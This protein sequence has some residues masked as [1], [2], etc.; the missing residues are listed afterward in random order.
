MLI[1][2]WSGNQNAVVIDNMDRFPRRSP[3][4]RCSGG[5]RWIFAIDWMPRH[6]RLACGALVGGELSKCHQ[7]ARD[8]NVIEIEIC[9]A[10]S[11]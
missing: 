6:Q 5:A 11:H 9:Y 10:G 7:R 4:R 1:D 8:A 3:F 2:E